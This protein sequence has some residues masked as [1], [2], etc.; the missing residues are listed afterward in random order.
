MGLQ[1]GHRLL[2]VGGAAHQLPVELLPVEHAGNSVQRHAV[3]IHKNDLHKTG[4][5]FRYKTTITKNR[6]QYITPFDA[7]AA[8][9]TKKIFQTPGPPLRRPRLKKVH[10]T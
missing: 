1:Q 10:P 4:G 9:F 6:P 3:V 5:S 8:N 2:P 7:A